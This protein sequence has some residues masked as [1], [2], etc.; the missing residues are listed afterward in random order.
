[1]S[2]KRVFL[3]SV[4]GGALIFRLLGISSRS[5]WYDE[6]FAV[7]FAEQ[8]PQA[9]LSGTL[10]PV[11][12]AAADV[13][14]LAYYT[15]LWAWM[16]AFGSSPSAVRMHS[17]II[18]LGLIG[19]VYYLAR[20]LFGERVGLVSTALVAFSPF[21]IHY[22]QEVRMYALMA[23]FL[24][25]AT[26]AIW[27]ATETNKATWWLMFSASAALAQYTHNL[28]VFYLL[29]LAVTPIL[30]R[31]W[32]A[33]PSV[34]LAGLGAIGLYFPWLLLVPAQFAKVQ[35][36][37]WTARPGPGRL[38]TTLLSFVTNLPLPDEWLVGG[39]FISLFIFV[40]ATWQTLKALRT[41]SRHAMRGLWLAYLAITPPLAL[42]A[43]SQWQP[44]YIERALLP[45][46][47]MFSV[48]VGWALVQTEIPKS[49]SGL[50]FSILIAGMGFGIY[51]HNT[52]R[53]FPYAPYAELDAYLASSVKADDVILHSNKLT[54][55]PAVYY[56]G[57][58]LQRYLADPPGSG[59]DT[60]AEPTQRVLGLLAYPSMESAT[61]GAKRVWFVI[62]ER[63][64]EEYKDLGQKTHP[65][66]AWLGAH[67]EL[68]RVENWDEVDLYVYGPES[69]H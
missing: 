36:A 65:H 66:L 43:F 54:M 20:E 55:L 1:M 45:S 37:Y 59:A 38:V 10:T 4:F 11:G 7:L 58:L 25:A 62:F 35:S 30:L 53:G 27:K 41:G 21:Q 3:I 32:R 17:V 9:M 51:Q 22:A 46:G 48:W 29:P 47:V 50:A 49:V 68:E 63:A 44:V 8:G 57:D 34:A 69:G 13:H 60:L 19:L 15:T 28:S 14:P 39:V 67:Y 6:A 61:S 42:F 56:D 31:K 16:S 18:G 23:F 2:G 64:V 12:G 26:L 24:I 40:L 5:L 52:Y 33:L